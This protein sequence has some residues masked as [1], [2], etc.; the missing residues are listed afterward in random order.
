MFVV[1]DVDDLK[2]KGNLRNLYKLKKRLGIFGTELYRIQYYLNQL[3]DNVINASSKLKD[4]LVLKTADEI[5]VDHLNI[6]GTK[7]PIHA[8]KNNGFKTLGD[9]FRFKGNFSSLYGLAE[10]SNYL[11]KINSSKLRKQIS[12]E[13]K[14]VISLDDKNEAAKAFICSIFSYAYL[15]KYCEIVKGFLNDF[16]NIKYTRKLVKKGFNILA[17]FSKSRRMSAVNSYSSYVNEVSDYFSDVRL[18]LLDPLN[19]DIEMINKDCWLLYENDYELFLSVAD[20]FS[21]KIY[22][23]EDIGKMQIAR[24]IVISNGEIEQILELLCKYTQN[25]DVKNKFL[26][27]VNKQCIVSDNDRDSNYK[28]PK[29]LLD[30]VCPNKDFYYSHMNL[31][32]LIFKECKCDMFDYL[33]QIAI[34]SNL[35][36]KKDG[37]EYCVIIDLDS[38]EFAYIDYLRRT[39]PTEMHKTWKYHPLYMPY[40][41]EIKPVVLKSLPPISTNNNRYKKDSYLKA[42]CDYVVFHKECGELTNE[43]LMFHSIITTE[44]YLSGVKKFRFKSESDLFKMIKHNYPDA[45]YQYR[46]FW[47]RR[48]S[49]DIYIPSLKIGIEYQGQQ[50]Y[51]PYNNS[52]LAIKNQRDMEMRDKNKKLLCDRYG[53]KLLYWK[54]DTEV[55]RENFNEFL[56]KVVYFKEENNV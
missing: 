3:K 27:F 51:I 5:N 48:Q 44:L 24:N 38:I 30:I 47:L 53:I 39:H 7:I 45:V 52:P 50:H 56:N 23:P 46:S 2:N 32:K 1:P 26:D 55:N 43:L 34:H 11:I 29:D 9:V 40:I 20:S 13:T 25:D 22:R 16:A 15:T 37:K 33:K 17:L 28:M 35:P 19:E 6:D 21:I 8:L 31:R 54:Y 14:Y 41:D 12:D 18:E 10:R 42:V 4:Y 36:M 49:L